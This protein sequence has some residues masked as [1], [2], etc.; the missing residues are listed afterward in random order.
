MCWQN[1]AKEWE[2]LWLSCPAKSP[3]KELSMIGEL[4]KKE[5][6]ELFLYGGRAWFFQE[7]DGKPF[8]SAAPEVFFKRSN[9]YIEEDDTKSSSALSGPEGKS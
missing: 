8:L 2:Q 3:H 1:D 6:Q 7:N 4:R 9:H 5:G